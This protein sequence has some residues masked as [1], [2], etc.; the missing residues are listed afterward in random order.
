MSGPAPRRPDRMRESDVVVLG[1]GV[2]GLTTALHARGR[3]VTV[4][5][6]TESAGGGSSVLAQGGV[7]VALGLDDS[8]TQHARDTLAVGCGLND[9]RVVRLVTEEGPRRI[10]HLLRLGA[11]LDRD[12]SGRLAMGQEAAHS[13][14]RVV[15]AAG[16]AT[17][18]ELVRALSDAVRG[19]PNVRF[20]DGVVALELV[21]D[22]GRVIG[23]MAIDGSGELVMHSS[24][25]VVLATGGIGQLYLHTTNPAEATADGL[26]MAARAGARLAGIEFVQF[27]PTALSVGENPLP[28]LTEALRGEGA[29]LVDETGS[30]FMERIHP[31]A[32]LAPRDIVARAIWRHQQDG[33]EAFLDATRLAGRIADRFPTV[34]ELC[35]QRGLD[36]RLQPMP[37]TPAAHY[38]MGGVAVDLDGRTSING[39][40]ACGEVAHTG[41]HGAN[42]LASNSL[43]E[44]L[45]FGSRIGEWLAASGPGQSAVRCGSLPTVTRLQVAH[46]PRLAGESAEIAARLR[47]VMWDGVGLERTAQGMRRAMWEIHRLSED[48]PDGVGE[49]VNL[50]D[51]A[52]LVARAAWA[53]TESRGAHY[54]SDIPWQ[55]HHWCQDL[56]FDGHE[57]IEPRPVAVAG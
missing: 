56:F 55:D 51:A 15:H 34:L 20:E 57:A 16:D 48:A 41:L 27:H 23:L 21:V 14:R 7:A 36:P 12:S 17:G 42:R 53:R 4:L 54:R 28:L 52:R 35:L 39:L 19:L 30:R 9:P 13:R 31:E 18:A 25:A 50:L 26:A 45:V 2:A 47:T 24:S 49:L 38:H 10:Q 11:R 37:V 5:S 29:V 32:E 3:R 46:T 6:K 43:L 40:W 1:S 22:H 8:P 33:H 44:A